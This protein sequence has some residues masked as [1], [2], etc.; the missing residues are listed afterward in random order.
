MKY[1]K[2][3]TFSLFC[4]STFAII[5][6][7][8]SNGQ[9]T[10]MQLKRE[11]I[12]LATKA[13]RADDEPSV[14]GLT[15]E[16]FDNLAPELPDEIRQPLKERVSSAD[17]KFRKHQHADISEAQIANGVNILADRLGAP[18]YARTSAEQVS[19]LRM[20]LLSAFPTLLASR[21]GPDDS[22]IHQFSPAEASFLMLVMARQKVSNAH[23]QVPPEQWKGLRNANHSSSIASHSSQRLPNPQADEMRRLIAT[24]A[25]AMSLND[26]I[27]LGHQVLDAIG[28]QR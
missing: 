17:I 18:P 9:G 20:N 23:Y 16:I 28:V 11:R 6:A 26:G 2:M 19:D 7:S 25:P 27:A 15:A 10:R 22:T 5:G 24:H 3:I 12:E 13:A 14:R 8:R 1:Q 21:L 4:L